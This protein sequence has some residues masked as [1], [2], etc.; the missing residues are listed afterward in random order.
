MKVQQILDGK[1]KQSIEAIDQSAKIGEA[2]T[3]LANLRIGSLVVSADPAKI[4]GILSERDIVRAIGQEGAAILDQPVS[5]IMTAKVRTI[6]PDQTAQSA[7]EIMS[8]G[9]FRHIP[10]VKDGI[11]IGMISIG[12]VISARLREIEHENNAMNELISGQAF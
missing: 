11:L 1:P 3:R 10:V 5:R 12:D 9:R 6:T 2:V 7:L 8:E 4:D